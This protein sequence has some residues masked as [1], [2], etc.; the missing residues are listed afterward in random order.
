[1][2]DIKD[3]DTLQDYILRYG[4]EYYK[5]NKY[6]QDLVPLL[7]SQGFKKIS[8]DTSLILKKDSKVII[9]SNDVLVK[10]YRLL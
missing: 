4:Q 9:I 8:N 10:D 7:I 3:T 6:Y 5:G 1:M 2:L